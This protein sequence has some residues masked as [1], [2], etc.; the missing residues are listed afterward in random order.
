MRSTVAV[1]RVSPQTVIADIAKVME[2]AGHRSVLNPATPTILKENISWHFPF[3]GANT[4]PWQLDG[5]IKALRSAGHQDLTCVGNK[6]VV[7]D[8]FKGDDLNKFKPVLRANNVPLR[9]NFKPQ[10][11]AWV[12]YQPKAQMRILD[13]I[14]PE[15]IYIPDFFIGRTSSICPRSSAISTPP[16]PAR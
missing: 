1:I 3:P 16:P 2:L 15:G 12:R 13:R 8:A 9:Y 6:T 10:D 4:T 5:V 14:Y 7:T 11:M